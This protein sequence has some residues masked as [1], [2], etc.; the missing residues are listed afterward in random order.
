MTKPINV[1]GRLVII[2]QN[3][4]LA[5]KKEDW[6][7]LPGGHVEYNESVKKT[8]IRECEE[9]FGGKV[10]VGDLI[11][12]LEHSFDP[13]GGPYHEIN[14]VFKGVLQDYNFPEVPKSLEDDLE[15][16][17]VNLDKMEECNLLP[18]EIRPM[19]DGQFDG[20]WM[21]TMK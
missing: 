3:N 1:L 17:W 9:E 8:V 20:K 2:D 15:V 7:F 12:I 6:C 10:T 16:V 21:S 19:I 18:K 11:G 14:F 4:V 5:V 13:G